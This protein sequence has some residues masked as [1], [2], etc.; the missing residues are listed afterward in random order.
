M[1]FESIMLSERSQT[2][3]TTHITIPFI[4]NVHNGQTYRDKRLWVAYSEE[5]GLMGGMGSYCYRV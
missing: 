2:Q 3:E 1:N 5:S 4:G